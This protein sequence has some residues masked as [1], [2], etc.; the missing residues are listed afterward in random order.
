V[1]NI[2]KHRHPFKYNSLKYSIASGTAGGKATIPSKTGY[3]TIKMI[4]KWLY[5]VEIVSKCPFKYIKITILTH[6]SF[7]DQSHS[8]E[9]CPKP[10]T[11]LNL[12]W[13]DTWCVSLP[14][15]QYKMYSL[16]VNLFTI[17]LTCRGNVRLTFSTT[18]YFPSTSMFS[19]QLF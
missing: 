15:I 10:N 16:W 7:I 2:C 18:E 3:W 6:H 19:N 12:V 1:T 4:S 14:Q 5:Q 11:L 17:A 9:M 13:Y 8:V